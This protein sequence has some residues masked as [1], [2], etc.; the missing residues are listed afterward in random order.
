MISLTTDDRFVTINVGERV[1][2]GREDIEGTGD[3]ERLRRRGHVGDGGP[4]G[5]GRRLGERRSYTHSIEDITLISLR[6]CD[7]NVSRCQ[8]Q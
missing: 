1:R 2:G 8:S 4:W 7:V 5:D 6:R 3:G